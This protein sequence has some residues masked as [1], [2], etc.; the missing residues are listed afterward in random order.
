MPAA[1][2][3]L[4]Q[5]AAGQV[6]TSVSIAS[7]VSVKDLLGGR[8][9]KRIIRARMVMFYLIYKYLPMSRSAD[10][11]GWDHTTIIHGH[12][13]TVDY[14]LCYQDTVDLVERAETV[15]KILTNRQDNGRSKETPK[16]DSLGPEQ[17]SG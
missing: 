1:E 11:M 12:R 15:Y 7:G 3:R 8:R 5:F 16:A 9:W 10:A 17:V 14:M 4:L 2:W 13:S 6:A